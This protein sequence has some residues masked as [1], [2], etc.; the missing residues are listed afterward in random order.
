VLMG[1][2]LC[3]HFKLSTP[4]QTASTYHLDTTYIPTQNMA[5][6]AMISDLSTWSMAILADTAAMFFSHLIRSL[7]P[8]VQQPA[9]RC[10]RLARRY[11]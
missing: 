3:A 7:P 6:F 2:R 10:A 1:G 8:S 11:S 9:E 4:H 5:S